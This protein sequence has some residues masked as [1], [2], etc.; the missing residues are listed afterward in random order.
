MDIIQFKDDVFTIENFLSEKECTAIIA[1]LDAITNAGILDWNQI[2]FFGSFAMGYWPSDPN[3]QYFGLPEDYFN[4][5]KNKIQNAGETVF[6]RPLKEVSYHAQKWVEGAFAAF[7][8]DNSDEYGNP[9]A[10]ERSKYAGFLY[11]NDNFDGGSLNFQHDDI[12]IKPKVGMLA[13]FKGGH[14]NEHEVTTVKN[15]ERY[16]VGSFWDDADSEYDEATMQRWEDELKETRA[17]QEEQYKEWD[18]N[19]KK[20]QAPQYKGKYGY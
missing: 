16:T 6:E 2:A 17:M 11:L 5:L 15:G 19:T 10:F 4:Q 3:L 7:H 1:Y 13:F 18:E 14:R 9:T 8:S 20:G 12:T